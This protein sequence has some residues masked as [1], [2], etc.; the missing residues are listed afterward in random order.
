M[1][2]LNT[3]E[4]NGNFLFGFG[5]RTLDSDTKPLIPI[6]EGSTSSTIGNSIRLERRDQGNRFKHES[7]SRRREIAHGIHSERDEKDSI[8]STGDGILGL[9]PLLKIMEMLERSEA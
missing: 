6:L 4:D 7:F 3:V 2:S 9:L 5:S 1:G 8:T